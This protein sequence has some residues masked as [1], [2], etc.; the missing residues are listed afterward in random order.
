MSSVPVFFILDVFGV[1][2]FWPDWTMYSPPEHTD[3]AFEYQAVPNGCSEITVIPPFVWPDT[4]AEQ[5]SGLHFYGAMLN[6]EMSAIMGGFATV[7]WGYGPT[8]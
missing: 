2:Y 8:Q 7:D 5:V 4:G 6:Q 3:I 1:L